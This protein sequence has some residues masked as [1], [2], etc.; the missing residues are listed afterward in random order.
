[1]K[2]Y[3]SY[4]DG[5]ANQASIQRDTHRPIMEPD[6][7]KYPDVEQRWW[8]IQ[9]TPAAKRSAEDV[10][11]FEDPV[12]RY[13]GLNDQ[14]IQQFKLAKEIRDRYAAELRKEQRVAGD[15]APVYEPVH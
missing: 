2:N 15:A 9:M 4:H 12:N 1:M 14:E 11:W 8:N 10:A 3:R 5:P 7:L 13:K 6:K